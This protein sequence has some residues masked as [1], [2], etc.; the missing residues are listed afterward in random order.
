MVKIPIIDSHTHIN[1]SDKEFN[2]F[3]GHLFHGKISAAGEFIMT[4]GKKPINRLLNNNIG[5]S[6][7]CIEK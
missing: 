4:I 2:V 3:G 1:F 5:L 7:W 6:L